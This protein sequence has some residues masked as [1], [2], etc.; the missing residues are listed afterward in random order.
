MVI[1]AF[2]YA[3][4]EARMTSS[5]KTVIGYMDQQ[6]CHVPS[7]YA[8]AL[9]AYARALEWKSVMH[10]YSQGTNDDGTHPTNDGEFDEC[11][12]K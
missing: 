3:M 10:T 2:A 4:G 5:L 6:R 1:D 12:W 7:A 8:S 11:D 9:S